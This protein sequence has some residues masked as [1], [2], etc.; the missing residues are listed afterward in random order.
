MDQASGRIT[1]TFPKALQFRL[2][3][4]LSSLPNA[5]AASDGLICPVFVSAGAIL[6]ETMNDRELLQRYAAERC[7]AAFTELVSRYL[8]LVYSAALRQVG[9]DA[10]LAQD[11]TQSVFIDLAR[12][13]TPLS[14]VTV[15]SGWLYTSARYAAGKIVRGE[16][17]RRVREQE[18]TLMQ[19]LSSESAPAPAW[20]QLR[21]VLDSVMHELNERDRNAVLL[22]YFESRPLAEVGDKLGLSEDA[23]RKRVGRALDKLRELLAQRG[24]TSTSTALVT[25]L[26]SQAVT[27]APA[28]LAVNI[29]G[30]ALSSAATGT[31]TGL[32]FL[33]IMT[34]TKLKLGAIGAL[35]VTGAAAPLVLQHQAQLKL[36]DENL[37]LRQ[38]YGAL[39][40]RL[41]P[42]AVENQRLS[43]LVAQAKTS[44]SVQN[45][46]TN[47]LLRLRAEV[48]RLRSDTRESGK[49]GRADNPNDAAIEATAEMLA[50]RATQLKQRL[51]QMP[52]LKIPELQFIKEKD[53]LD[54]VS[55]LKQLETEE[56]FRKA[57][58]DLR[59]NAKNNFGSVLQKALRKFTDASGGMLPTDLSQLQPYFDAPV[60]PGVLGRYQLLQSGRLADVGVDNTLVGE[61]AP[62]VDDENDSRFEFSLTG[63][64]RTR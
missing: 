15:L 35:V 16:Q 59:R 43:N 63:T 51:E 61:I 6:V 45:D 37:T 50:A 57:L 24:V 19:E 3:R 40:A 52:N 33:K 56:D 53:W 4:Q 25:I 39:A 7:E 8:D 18:A 58:S 11:V 46:R 62:P 10:G 44:Q 27:A 48:A 49:G 41:A 30:A 26:S 23:A 20:D 64:I 17:R 2:I 54:A 36:V 21:P 12:K 1:R 5:V 31:S 14:R 29:A 34:M 32:T 60:D 13:A 55:N 28:G 42:L 9:G 22:R 47:E 38:Q